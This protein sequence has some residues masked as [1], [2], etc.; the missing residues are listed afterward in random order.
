MQ[1]CALTLA[2]VN[3]VFQLES[4]LIQPPILFKVLALQ[5]PLENEDQAFSASKE[6]QDKGL[7]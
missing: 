1:G 6:I 5:I 4:I 3:S 2:K 7:L